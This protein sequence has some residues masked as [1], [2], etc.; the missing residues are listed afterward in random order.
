MRRLAILL[1]IL[2]GVAMSQ[3]KSPAKKPAKISARTQSALEGGKKGADLI[4]LDGKVWTGDRRAETAAPPGPPFT[5]QAVAISDDRILDV[6]TNDQILRLAR[7]DTKILRLGGRLVVP[8]CIDSH[9]HFIAGG[10]QLLRLNLK[11]ARTETEFVRLIAERAKSVA[12]GQWLQGGGWDEQAWP[13]RKLPTRWEIDAV[14]PGIPVFLNRYDDHMALANSLALRLAGITRDTKEPPGGVIVR[15]PASGEPTGLVKDAAMDLVTS[16]IPPPTEA[17]MEGAL[18]AALKEASRLGVTSVHN[19]TTDRDSTTGSFIGEIRLLQRAE[20][21]GW[22]TVRQY[23]IIPIAG[24][25]RL[26]EVGGA[27]SLRSDFVKVRAVKGFADGSLG[28]ATA[29]MFEPFNDE[30][31]N[32]GLPM[33]L[34]DPPARMEA[35]VREAQRAG[36]QPCIHAIGDRAVAEVLDLYARLGGDRV[37]RFRI[38][39]AQHVRAQDFERFANLGVIASMQP[40]HAV[41]DGRWAEKRLGIARSGTSFAWRSMLAAGVPL[42]FGSDWPVAPL[43][44]LLG[45]YAAVTRAT[46]D[47]RHP[48]GWFP[49]ERLTVEEALRAYTA[50]GAYAAF[51]E[52]EKG[53][54]SPG[55]LADVVVLSED[56]LNTS[57]DRIRETRIVMTIV[58]GRIVYQAM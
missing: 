14:T 55:K 32:R 49:E 19:I 34:M 16:V 4:L 15:D 38:E 6:G 48:D 31:G 20:R 5:A 13:S 57:P 33:A 27:E 7:R 25:G 51:E 24:M 2:S 8:G 40:Y 54:L 46:L 30:P 42:V 35:L 26:A 58:A 50:G 29:W 43:D 9:V 12:S 17:E 10:F 22:L 11:N 23:A 44:P 28:S 37:S 41:D 3:E 45:I 56:I 21:E 52:K 1:L 53:T 47:G 39:H 18:R 36:L